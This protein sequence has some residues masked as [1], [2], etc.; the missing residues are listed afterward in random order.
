MPQPCFRSPPQSHAEGSPNAVDTP[1][2]CQLGSKWRSWCCQYMYMYNDGRKRRT[3]VVQATAA[4]SVLHPIPP[5][6]FISLPC[7]PP[8]TRTH[9]YSSMHR[10]QWTVSRKNFLSQWMGLTFSFPNVFRL[11][12]SAEWHHTYSCPAH[13]QPHPH[14]FGQRNRVKDFKVHG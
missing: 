4:W 1:A 13:L 11:R 9:P 3:T 14:K 6:T 8:C 7:T 2:Q 5:F 10:E 12:Q